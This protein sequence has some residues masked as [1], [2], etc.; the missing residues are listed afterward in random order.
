MKSLPTIEIANQ[1]IYLGALMRLDP[2]LYLIK[3]ALEQTGVNPRIL[4][5][6][7]RSVAN[8]A[9][10]TGFGKIQVFM[11]SRVVTSIK[12]EEND[13]LDLPAVDE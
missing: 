13:L 1:E 8:L 9:Y 2:D 7:I 6:F 3:M 4:P 10:G 11:S 5:R 12:P